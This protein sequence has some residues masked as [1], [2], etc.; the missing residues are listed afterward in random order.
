[1]TIGAELNIT[2]GSFKIKRFDPIPSSFGEKSSNKL[3]T[4]TIELKR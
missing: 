2:V 4:F 1:M 3:P